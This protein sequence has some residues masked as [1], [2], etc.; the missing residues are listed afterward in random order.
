MIYLFRAAA[1]AAA[2]AAS[3]FLKTRC[4]DFLFFFVLWLF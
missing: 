4:G 1:A 3:S 2:A